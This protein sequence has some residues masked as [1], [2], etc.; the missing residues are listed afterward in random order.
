MFD[1]LVLTYD[2]VLNNDWHLFFISGKSSLVW[3]LD[4]SLS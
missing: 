4:R 2:I 3:M 1:I